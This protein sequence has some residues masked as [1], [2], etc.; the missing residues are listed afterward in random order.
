MS[1]HKSFDFDQV[2]RYSLQER[3]SK[4]GVEEMANPS[5]GRSISEF[6]DSLPNLLGARDLRI[7]ADR[8]LSA[9]Q[10]RK[11]IIWGIG[12]HV[13]KVGLAP[14]LIELMKK[15]MATA[16]AG[17]GSAAIHDFELG[18]AGQTS[19]DVDE[20]LGTGRFGMAEETGSLI[21]RAI[22]KGYAGGKGLG[23][24]LGEMM[25][26]ERVD[27]ADHSLMLQAYRQGVPFT[28]HVAIGTDIIHA[29]PGASGEALGATSHTDFK[30][31]TQ[32][33]AELNQGGVYLNIGSAVVL[34]EVFLKAVSAVRSTTR[35][36]EDFTTANLDFIQHYRPLQNVVK[37]PVSKSGLGIALTGHHE[38]MV[39]LLAARLLS[40]SQT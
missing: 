11:P 5:L 39:P 32:Q 34:P 15:G 2:R 33:V 17:N 23:E 36:L 21:N 38:I 25:D 22:G 29:H 14:V 20:A 26:E 8:I 27:H 1:R 30:I 4:V 31:F 7:L 13:I 40:L 10:K 19:E 3:S 6:F 12:G 28:V 18:F 9:R 24:V 16:F 35:E 37:R